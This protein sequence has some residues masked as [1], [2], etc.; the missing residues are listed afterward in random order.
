LR[1]PQNDENLIPPPT[2]AELARRR[3][4]ALRLWG[5]GFTQVWIARRLNVA[6]PTVSRWVRGRY[7]LRALRPPQP[8]H[9]IPACSSAPLACRPHVMTDDQLGEVWETRPAE[10]WTGSAFAAALAEAFGVRYSVRYA[11]AL[12]G[13][14]RLGKSSGSRFDSTRR[15]VGPR[16]VEKPHVSDD[17]RAASGAAR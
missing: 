6:Q 14:L 2:D 17:W 8:E 12:L 10:S 9:L 15:H 7:R 3:E 1:D 11:C 16:T 4:E 5:E 13:R